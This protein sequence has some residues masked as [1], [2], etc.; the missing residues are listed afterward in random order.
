[1]TPLDALATT[2]HTGPA[3]WWVWPVVVASIAVPIAIVV[4]ALVVASKRRAAR[5]VWCDARSFT[6]ATRGA[7]PEQMSMFKVFDHGHSRG[8]GENIRGTYEGQPFELYD[9]FFVTGS[10]KQRSTHHHTV[11]QWQTPSLPD[12]TLTPEGWLTRLGN[13]LGGQDIDFDDDREFSRA[14]QLK[15]SDV[16]AIRALFTYDRRRTLTSSPTT[17]VAAGYGLMF[18]WQPGGLPRAQDLDATLAG[19]AAVRRLFT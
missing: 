7:I 11:V 12:F 13:A 18:V 4:I 6:Y 8:V 2:K 5:R 19:A 9:Y 10:G 16:E 3:P 15:G 1:V 17:H 14:F